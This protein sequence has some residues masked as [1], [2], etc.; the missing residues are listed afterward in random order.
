M[1]FIFLV[2]FPPI[3]SSPVPKRGPGRPP[4]PKG[5]IPHTNLVR[6]NQV[7][8]PLKKR[9][10]MVIDDYESGKYASKLFT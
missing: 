5:D 7:N 6:T 1:Y 3:E 4:K 2:S 8:L 9:H 10:K